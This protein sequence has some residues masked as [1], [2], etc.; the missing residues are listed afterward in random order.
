[1]S[2]IIITIALSAFFLLFFGVMML[3]NKVSHVIEQIQAKEADQELAKIELM[4]NEEQNQNRLIPKK[5]K[6]K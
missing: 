2:T 4:M 1:M 3:G 6:K 5:R